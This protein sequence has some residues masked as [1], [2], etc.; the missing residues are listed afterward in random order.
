V[1]VGENK[2][3]RGD[4]GGERVAK[5]KRCHTQ[6]WSSHHSRITNMISHLLV[7]LI[8]SSRFHSCLSDVATEPE[9]HMEG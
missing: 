7:F 1:R 5:R 4:M 6:S 2:G 9:D 8:A 3:R